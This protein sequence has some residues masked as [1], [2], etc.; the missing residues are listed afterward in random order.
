MLPF[1]CSKYVSQSVAKANGGKVRMNEYPQLLLTDRLHRTIEVW[2]LSA[3]ST[4][5]SCCRKC[6]PSLKM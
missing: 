2:H 3:C 6:P 4:L 1:C 5:P